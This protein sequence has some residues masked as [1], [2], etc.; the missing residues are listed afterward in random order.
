MAPAFDLLAPGS[1]Q[2]AVLCA[3]R[4]SGLVVIAPVFS[5]TAIPRLVRVA[6][7]VVL[8][9]LLQ[10]VAF[11]ARGAILSL[12]PSAVA[13]EVLIGFA[14]GLGAAVIIGAAEMAGDAMAVQMGLSGSAIL[15]P[16]D[17][18]QL[19]VLGVFLRVFAV[20][21]LLS[22]DLHHGMLT[23][24][25]DSFI[26]APAGAPVSLSGGILAMVHAG[27]EL[28]ALGFRFA[29]PVIAVVF[30][31]TL[32]LAL[33]NRAAQQLNLLTVSFPVQIAVGLVALGAALPTLA[34]VL[35]GWDAMYDSLLNQFGRGFAAGAR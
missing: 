5:S 23:A 14:I 30:I 28:F 11:G 6:T 12:T 3:A 33:L 20:A 16:L 21:L 34:H 29:A 18:T 7:L 19:P 10:P 26:T 31:V 2:A 1:A 15:D 24:L 9:V 17:T 22:L 8:T 13:G 25:A 32:A 35:G 27:S 4:I